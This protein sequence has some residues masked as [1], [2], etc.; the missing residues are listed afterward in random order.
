MKRAISILVAVILAVVNLN[1]VIVFAEDLQPITGTADAQKYTW[2][3]GA[4][5]EGAA[6]TVYRYSDEYADLCVAVGRGDNITASKGI[7]FSD[8]SC[9]EADSAK[10]N[11]RYILVKPAYSG[12]LSLNIGFTNATSSAKGRLMYYDYGE[13]SGVDEA[14]TSVL[15]KKAT[16]QD[17]GQVQAG[18]DFT[19]TAAKTVSID[20][21]AGHTYAI[22]TYNRS[23]YIS[24]MYYTSDSIVG[25][26][27]A[28]SIK[29]PVLATDTE[30]LGTCVDGAAVTVVINGGIGQGATVDGTDWSLQGVSLNA[31]DVISVTAKAGDYKE[32]SIVEATVEPDDS[33]CAIIVNDTENGTVTTN[34][35]DNS[36]V[37]KG[38]L[39]VLTVTPADQYKLA[40]LTVG[41]ETVSV[42][43]NNSYSFII[44][45]DTEVSAIFEAKPYHTV[46][47][48]A[49]TA[50]GEI[51]IVDGTI[52]ENG[53]IKAV[54]GDQVTLSVKA[55]KDYRIK[56]LT[57]QSS[58]KPAEEI[59]YS[60]SFIM[61]AGDVTVHA[62][63]KEE[64]VISKID[65]TFDT[66]DR[67]TMTVA[68]EPFFYNGIQVRADNA[69]DQKGY[70]DEQIKHMYE[71]AGQD[72]FTVANTQIRWSDVQPDTELYATDTAY[73]KG[74]AT[75][76]DALS[77]S[78]KAVVYSGY[79]ADDQSNQSI[80]YVKFALP[81]IGDG[82]EY[83][84]AKF[85]IN[86][87][88]ATADTQLSVY[89]ISDNSWNSDSITWDNAIS[90][91]NYEIIDPEYKISSLEWDQVTGAAYYGFDVT[92]FINANKNNGYVSF[93]VL[94]DSES[95]VT[96]SGAEASAAPLLKLSRDDVY[97]FTYLDKLIG[98][99]EEAG[100]K[101]EVLWFATDTCQQTYEGRVPYYVHNN[102]QKALK[103]DGTPARNMGPLN[104][105]IMCKNDLEL[106]AKEKEVLETVF[107][108]I[109]QYN[110][111]H[112]N[113]NT[114]V[115]CQVANEPAVG[116]LHVGTDENKYFERCRCE[117][118]EKEYS[119]C[120]E[121]TTTEA[122]ALYEYQQRTMWGYLN[123][124]SSAVKESEYSVWTRVN[125][126]MGT[127]ANVLAYN[128][129]KRESV[130]TDLD[131]VGIDPYSTA[132]GS[133]NDY[134]Y[135]FGH[136]TSSYK[137]MTCDYSLGKNFPLVM[138]Y[139][140]NNT[141]VAGSILACI[142][143]G[144][145][146]NIYEIL[147]G[148]EDFGIYVDKNNTGEISQRGDYVQQLRD[149]NAMLNK[150]KYSLASKKPDG[151]D[152]DSL[153]FFNPKSDATVTTS[154]KQV[155]ALDVTY[156]TD[157]NGVGIVIGESDKEIVLLST[158]ASE[159]KIS[160]IQDYKIQSVEAGAFDGTV[161]NGDGEKTYT[162]ND[163]NSVSIHMAAYEC[164]KVSVAEAI[165]EAPRV[166]P[167]SGNAENGK[168]QWDFGI[169]EE[170][171][172]KGTYDYSDDYA[173]I[174]LATGMND[175][176]TAGKGIY[177]SD[178]SCKEA[179]SAK[180]SNRYFLITPAYSGKLSL[181]V[182]FEGATTSGKARMWYYDYGQD[183]P[184][185][186]ADTSI[187]K[188]KSGAQDVG[189]IQ[190]GND[191][192]DTTA[193]TESFDVEAG[194]TYAVYTYNKGSYISEMYYE[195]DDIVV[196][197]EPG[198]RMPVGL[199]DITVDENGKLRA[200]LSYN[201]E[202]DMGTV[203]L[204]A[205]VYRG[206][207]VESIKAFDISSEGN[208]DFGETGYTVETEK[209]I[210]L[211]VWDSLGG[212]TPLSRVYTNED[213]Q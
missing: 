169:P 18:S 4:P 133:D 188:K 30:I 75:S 56:T 177:F 58:E 125:N 175:S 50:N 101:F 63:F 15:K 64:A 135:S 80:A 88:A 97:D 45:G 117:V 204:I 31:G 130:G 74:G 211:F 41:G 115:G 76:Q 36:R 42:D 206:G 102:Y 104:S 12:T 43:Q 2:N 178:S 207:T 196:T 173:S 51:S 86:V 39:V 153:L 151:A 170:V 9:K 143:G 87:T 157:N 71:L 168:Y 121:S 23:S 155:R 165:P 190:I 111:E 79:D 5:D 60:N 92:D 174:R 91:S 203:S 44:E 184:A 107:D 85:R 137:G 49:E 120:V 198:D 136:E 141:T 127:D 38:E 67:L 123:N 81:G 24:Q 1:F 192:T 25:K 22:Y 138:E 116:R 131:M 110:K 10:D 194:H 213:I 197:P 28:P 99:A 29:T 132:S 20:V 164:V 167:I 53:V 73:I 166:E 34:Q 186:E 83:A 129:E 144:G 19:T 61:P 26:T 105:F 114:V 11:N 148:K 181:K 90:H 94:C 33:V 95:T 128:E 113:K 205:A 96:I 162:S 183:I 172:G 55:G 118:C 163:D 147:S 16:G 103:A 98:Y 199:N 54:E 159:F 160:D 13:N 212:M 82:G 189:Q 70:S 48:P 139:G 124:L 7:Y 109:S 35:A 202:G 84:A 14:D 179:D 180:D 21:S 193:R 32:S 134:L 146:F 122:R 8:S 68:G 52:E 156:N 208:I 187:L 140:G 89:G 59:K 200:A 185:N 108:H 142:G 57:Y 66:Y 176:V 37:K 149:T 3:F 112:G 191:F 47:L 6:S 40:A 171:Q 65:T 152:G 210:K 195:S 77:A 119:K 27:A 93:A 158:T 145:F 46:T 154:A 182:S 106:R 201:G 209:E 69:K 126:Y 72:G 100:L 78:N 150:V 62:E 161:W 17:I